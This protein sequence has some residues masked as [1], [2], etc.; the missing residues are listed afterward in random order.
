VDANASSNKIHNS[1]SV[2]KRF[3]KATLRAIR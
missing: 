2:S 3:W 1:K